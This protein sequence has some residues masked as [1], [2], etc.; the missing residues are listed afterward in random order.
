VDQKCQA[1]LRSIQNSPIGDVGDGGDL[2]IIEPAG[3]VGLDRQDHAAL[4]A[5]L[6]EI[7]EIIFRHQVGDEPAEIP[8]EPLARIDAV[9]HPSGQARHIRRELVTVLLLEELVQAFGPVLEADLVAVD[10]HVAENFPAS[11]APQRSITRWTE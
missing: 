1:S 8:E 6:L 7:A 2:E 11:S 5:E 9:D 4:V 10:Q 3:A